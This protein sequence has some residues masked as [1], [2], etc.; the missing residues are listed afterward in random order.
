MPRAR[1]EEQQ[2]ETR[3]SSV[4]TETPDR[5]MPTGLGDGFNMGKEGTDAQS[6]LLYLHDASHFHPVLFIPTALSPGQV[7]Q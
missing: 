1:Q 3:V 5:S 6:Q 2:T 7:R 4:M